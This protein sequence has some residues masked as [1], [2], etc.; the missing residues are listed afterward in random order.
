MARVSRWFGQKTGAP[1][2]RRLRAEIAARWINHGAATHSQFRFLFLFF[3]IDAMF[4]ERLTVE[5]RIIEG[6]ARVLSNAWAQ[7]CAWLFDLRSE[8][9]HGGAAS[10]NEW[11]RLEKYRDHFRSEPSED[12]EILA[13]TS[14]RQFFSS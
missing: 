10:I 11:I 9:V 12:I 5:A 4:G 6:V 2:K 7:K 3:A 8:L 1:V 13:T 14:L